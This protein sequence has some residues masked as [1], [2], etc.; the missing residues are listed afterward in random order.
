M[1]KFAG[2]RKMEE[3]TDAEPQEGCAPPLR[4]V[5][6]SPGTSPHGPGGEPERVADV[7]SE[8]SK[9]EGKDDG[10]ESSVSQSSE[11]LCHGD[12]VQSNMRS[13][14]KGNKD[15]ED[16]ESSADP[17]K[18]P[19]DDD[20]AP[21]NSEQQERDKT[22]PTAEEEFVKN[23]SEFDDKL[24]EEDNDTSL[25]EMDTTDH[26]RLGNDNGDDNDEDRKSEHELDVSQSTLCKTPAGHDVINVGSR[27][28]CG[29]LTLRESIVMAS[30]ANSEEGGLIIST[31]HSAFS[32]GLA[33]TPDF[34][35]EVDRA[36]HPVDIG[37]EVEIVGDST[38]TTSRTPILESPFE[39]TERLSAAGSESRPHS[40]SLSPGVKSTKSRK[41]K[42][43][44]KKFS[45]KK[46]KQRKIENLLVRRL[47][48]G[49]DEDDEEDDDDGE[50]ECK[51]PA[52]PTDSIELDE[53]LEKKLEDDAAKNNLTAINVKSILH[54]SYC[55]CWKVCCLF[56]KRG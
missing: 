51:Q 42:A 53:E 39:E 49:D 12:A 13:K 30:P 32:P 7:E 1:W 22:K 36:R 40:F 29:E 18:R 9:G 24:R 15:K 11:V 45:L 27:T 43:R 35:H 50:P 21:V 26:I 3:G 2:S 46:S 6:Q 34:A 28:Q 52:K 56:F 20:Q 4:E 16:L 55:I 41:R 10:S 19:A 14:R 5:E 48:V 38:P 33:L 44:H 23:T 25:E 17:S 31:P 8:D 37:S 47:L 54:V